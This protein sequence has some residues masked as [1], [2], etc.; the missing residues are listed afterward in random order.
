MS[1]YWSCTCWEDW[2]LATKNLTTGIMC[3]VE[4]SDKY[5]EPMFVDERE[6]H[7]IHLT[8]NLENGGMYQTSPIVEF[9][10]ENMKIITK[11]K[12]IYYLK[13]PLNQY[14]LPNIRSYFK[15]R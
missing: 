13:T 9:D 12:S 7:S 4:E 10:E 2:F 11:N 6:N 1:A 14:Q 3:F 8:I 5:T 15:D